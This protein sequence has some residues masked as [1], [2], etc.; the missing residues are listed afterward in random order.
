[1]IKKKKLKF[2]KRL[3]DRFVKKNSV[4]R[5]N[6]SLIN[7][8]KLFTPFLKIISSSLMLINILAFSEM[9]VINAFRE[10]RKFESENDG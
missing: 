9:I 3:F 4:N 2:F 1:M 5:Y 7:E 6:K 8:F 10:F